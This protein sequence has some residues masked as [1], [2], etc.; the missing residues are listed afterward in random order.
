[1]AERDEERLLDHNYDGIQEYDNPMPRWWLYI[2]WATILFAPFY[3]LYYHGKDGRSIWDQ[4][5]TD[6]L[7]FF[8]MQAQELLAMGPI[9]E[10]TLHGIQQDA[11]KMA[12]AAQVYSARCV[13]CH[14]AKGEG[15][16]GPN[17]TDEYWLHGGNL[18]D[19]Y[20]TVMEGV[21]AKGMLAWKKQLPLGD[22]LAVSAYVGS[23]RG[24]APPNAKTPQGDLFE[25]DLDAILASEAAE[26]SE[27]GEGGEGE[28][29]TEP[30]AAES[31]SDVTA[32]TPTES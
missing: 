4:Y 22:I 19:I 14:G 1:M 32:A 21:P 31:D 17:L 25:Y 13:Q 8:D 6:M 7:A 23:M 12:A 28:N 15:N 16:I 29:T 9:Q 18:T 10:T 5:N 11:S 3:L 26:A 2:F 24:T 20:G 30:G 27:A